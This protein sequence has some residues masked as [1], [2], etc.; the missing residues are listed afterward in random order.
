MFPVSNVQQGRGVLVVLAGAVNLQFHAEKAGPGAVENGTG[1]KIVVVDGTV[2]DGGTAIAAIGVIVVVG[3]PAL[4]QGDETAAAGAAVDADLCHAVQ[5]V[6][7]QQA[8][9]E[10]DQV[11]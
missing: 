5:V 1:L 6:R 11:V 3:V 4:V 8:V 9:M 2:L 10:F 7:T